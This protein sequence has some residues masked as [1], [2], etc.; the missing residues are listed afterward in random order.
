MLT[1][2]EKAPDMRAIFARFRIPAGF[3]YVSAA[4]YRLGH[5]NDTYRVHVVAADGAGTSRDYVL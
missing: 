5:I 3:A 1:A 2:E 4:P